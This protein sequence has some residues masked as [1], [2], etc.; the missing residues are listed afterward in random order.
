M[1]RFCA[2][3]LAIGLALSSIPADAQS[4]RY[5]TLS[6]VFSIPHPDSVMV[7]EVTYGVSPTRP[8]QRELRF[9]AHATYVRAVRF[10][11]A[12][13]EYAQQGDTLVVRLA[14]PMRLASRS[15]I[16]IE[17]LVNPTYGV[18]R[19]PKNVLWTSLMPGAQSHWIPVPLEKDVMVTTDVRFQIPDSYSAIA[20]GQP[21]ASEAPYTHWSSVEP[22]ALSSVMIAAGQLDLRRTEQGTY[23]LHLPDDRWDP[24][25]AVSAVDVRFANRPAPEVDAD[26]D[27]LRLALDITSEDDSQLVIR[28]RLLSGRARGN[29]TL[30]MRQY[31]GGTIIP[32]PLT[33]ASAGDEIRMSTASRLD[34]LT[35]GDELTEIDVVESKPG[36]FWLYQLRTSTDPAKRLDAATALG[37]VNDA[38]DIGLALSS[39]YR[40]EA[41]PAVKS[42]LLS[43]YAA[44]S[45]GR[46]GSHPLILT[47]LRERGDLR[48]VAMRELGRYTESQPVR[49]AVSQTIRTSDD[50]PLV[51]EALRTYQRLVTSDVSDDL[52]RR[53]LN[54]DADA[55]FA[56]T[57]MNAFQGRQEA[58]L[59]ASR[60]R[61]YLDGKFSWEVRKSAL[62]ILTATEKDSSSFR[63]V[64]VR[65]AADPDPR[66]R[67]AL[68]DAVHRLAPEDRD[69]FVRD[70]LMKEYD[71]RLSARI[72]SM[73]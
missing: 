34:N 1:I 31:V 23:Q 72:R 73:D 26:P 40:S 57:I 13:V 29:I 21:V 20:P 36:R 47:A 69:A 39:F 24:S 17:Y 54:E 11:D 19:W 35:V 16:A 18:H 5:Q 38:P 3:A 37:L 43:S 62:S 55:D 12:A 49:D 25:D 8:S 42:A 7:A 33:V 50:I 22:V 15:R 51:N 63:D 52:M 56:L 67:N 30:P 6:A 60:A 53:L 46:I 45:A 58:A 14:A 27:R 44:Q 71:P 64:F 2:W 9:L 32:A 41:D 28:V 68:L 10:N 48:L 66:F 61:F 59:I 65:H 70:R 4:L